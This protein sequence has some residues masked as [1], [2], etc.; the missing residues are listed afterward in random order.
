[1]R[2]HVENA[3]QSVKFHVYVMSVSTIS[4]CVALYELFC[5]LQPLVL[6]DYYNYLPVRILSV[7]GM[8]EEILGGPGGPLAGLF[9]LL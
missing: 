8:K 4:I 6:V 5:L 3:L 7:L 1:M 9:T 2:E